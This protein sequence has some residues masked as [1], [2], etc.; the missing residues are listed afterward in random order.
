MAGCE[1]KGIRETIEGHIPGASERG[2][3]SQ[4]NWLIVGSLIG[5]ASRGAE[6]YIGDRESD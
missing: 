5:M 4:W 2:W 1:I 6:R 3:V